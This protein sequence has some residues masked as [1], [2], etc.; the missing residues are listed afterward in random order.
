[1]YIRLTYWV[2]EAGSHSIPIQASEFAKRCQEDVL[3]YFDSNIVYELKYNCIVCCCGA[4]S[5]HKDSS[6]RLYFLQ[7]RY[8]DIVYNE[9]LNAVKNNRL[10]LEMDIRNMQLA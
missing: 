10:F 6:I 3:F 9:I 7:R 1:M 8:S 5:R 4:E 2:P